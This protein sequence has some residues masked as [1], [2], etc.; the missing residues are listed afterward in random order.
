MKTYI[1]HNLSKASNVFGDHIRPPCFV[2]ESFSN[3]FVY[4]TLKPFDLIQTLINVLMKISLLSHQKSVFRD[5]SFFPS[6]PFIYEPIVIK[7]NS[8]N[9]IVM[10]T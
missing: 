6:S 8:M 7:K 3:S 4:F 9:A 1:F 10:K 2:I 5:F